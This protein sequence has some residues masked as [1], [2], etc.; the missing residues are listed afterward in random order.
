[1]KT[2]LTNL[3]LYC[4]RTAGFKRRLPDELSSKV[5]RMAEKNIVSPDPKSVILINHVAGD[6]VVTAKH[7]GNSI[8]IHSINQQTGDKFVASIGKCRFCKGYKPVRK[9]FTTR[10]DDN[11]PY[12]HKVMGFAQTYKVLSS[13]LEKVKI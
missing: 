4:A 3:G 7:F 6:E 1:M 12:D 13:L 11:L 10:P 9:A 2:M 8:L 5:F